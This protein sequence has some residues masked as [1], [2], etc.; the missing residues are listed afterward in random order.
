[1]TNFYELKLENDRLLEITEFVRFCQ[2]NQNKDIEI[3]VNNEG[4][5][6]RYCGVY[7]ILDI[8]QFSSVDIFTSNSIETHPH[9]RIHRTWKTWL[10]NIQS[11]D[12]AFDYTWNQNKIFGCFFGR[13][14]APR[15]G[16]AGHLLKNHPDISLIITKFKFSDEDS[17]SQ[18]DVHR[19]FEWDKKSIE[20]MSL[21]EKHTN[22]D[23]VYYEKG[24]YNQNNALSRLYKDMLI[25]IVS[26]PVNAGDTF[27]PTEKIVRAMLCKRP[28]LAMA[29]R[30]YL[31]YLRQLG[32]HT[33]RDFWSEDYDGLDQNLRYSEI[34]ALIDRLATIP[35]YQMIEMYDQMRYLLDHNYDLLVNQKYNN[36]VE[37]IND[38]F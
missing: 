14:S 1:M 33:F 34:L 10:L 5:C 27:Y 9:Y 13:P 2:R 22:C 35:K 31:A 17:R 15:L 12:Y 36:T 19:L 16:I 23:D 30:N 37:K 3:K 38:G 8:F 21:I 7:D 4:H 24:H 29:S 11:F 32:F 26:E 28:F 18:F 6:L 20:N 25:D